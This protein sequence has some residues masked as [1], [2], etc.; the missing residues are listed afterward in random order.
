[1]KEEANFHMVFE[2]DDHKLPRKRK[3]WSHYEHGEA[4]IEFVS[5]AEKYYR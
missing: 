1:M 5:K 2:E 4:P 3:V